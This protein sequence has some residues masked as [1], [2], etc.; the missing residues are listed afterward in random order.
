MAFR[1]TAP[2]IV[3][4]LDTMP[5][6]VALLVALTDEAEQAL[7]GARELPLTEFPVKFGRAHRS[8]NVENSSNDVYLFER[9][10]STSL[11][12]SGE[13][14]EIEHSENQFF[15]VDRRSSCGTIV[16]GARIGGRRAGGRAPL[17]DGDEVVVGT[18]RSPFVFRFIVANGHTG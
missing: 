12:I 5:S 10:E 9:E 4:T 2:Y 3:A 7:G 11:H 18:R 17:R 14:F 6:V 16:G 15:L 8:Q 1:L 13:H